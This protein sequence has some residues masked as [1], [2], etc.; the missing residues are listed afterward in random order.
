M[1]QAEDI[2]AD[3]AP[4]YGPFINNGDISQSLKQV[5]RELPSWANLNSAQQE[6]LDFIFSKIGR[7]M[8]G[9][10]NLRDSWDDIAGYATLGSQHCD[11]HE[12]IDKVPTAREQ[13]IALI[14][15][16]DFD[17]KSYPGVRDSIMHQLKEGK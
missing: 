14:K 15:E 6:S 13:A 17:E 1:V 2:I 10:P 7:I 11:W 16:L 12:E 4:K 3:R 8:S 9:D 5:C